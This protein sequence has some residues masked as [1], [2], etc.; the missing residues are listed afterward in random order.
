MK[1]LF[2]ILFC[3]VFTSASAQQVLDSSFLYIDAPFPSCHAATIAQTPSG[4]LVAAFFGGSWEGCKD[5]CIYMC[6]KDRMSSHW[7]AP[8]VIADGHLDDTTQHPCWNPVLF[9][10]P[11]NH[12]PLVLWYKTGIYIKDWVAHQQLSFDGGRH[13]ATPTDLP[14]HR[15]GPIK[16]KPILHKGRII[17]PSSWENGPIWHTRFEYSNW[18]GHG[19]HWNTSA[20]NTPDSIRS[21]Q[22]TILVHR[23]G[24]LQALCRTKEGVLSTT[25]SYDNGSTWTPEVLTNIPHNNS[26]IDAMTLSDGRFAMV[27]NPIGLTIGQETGPRTPLVLA[28]SA[29]GLHWRTVLTLEHQPG[30][31]SYPTIIQGRDKTLHIVYTWNRRRIKYVHIA[32]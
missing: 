14:P 24:S 5:V 27:Y 12:Q 8:I 4:D 9:Q 22:P 23:D 6:R 25:Y 7:S 18:R 10:L 32:L 2:L 16:N 28:L 21:I 1:K 11:G 3:A 29:D 30:E 17:C 19:F 31:Y 15:L 20:P 13:W 26:G